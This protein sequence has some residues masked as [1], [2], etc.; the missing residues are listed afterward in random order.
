M[1]INVFETFCD[2]C[3]GELIDQSIAVVKNI[4]KIEK[5]QRRRVGIVPSLD[6][7]VLEKHCIR[8][9]QEPSNDLRLMN[10]CDQKR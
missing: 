1:S 6:I 3:H 7:R 5:G 2:L 4:L 9:E 10:T 8:E